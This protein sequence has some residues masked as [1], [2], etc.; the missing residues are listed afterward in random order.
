M[1][2]NNGRFRIITLRILV[3]IFGRP[4][5][6]RFALCYRTVVC[7]VLSVPLVYCGQT[8]GWTTMPLRTGIV[9]SPGHIVLDGTQLPSPKEAQQ[10]PQFS[11]NVYC[12]QTDAHLSN[13][14]ALFIYFLTSHD[15]VLRQH[16]VLRLWRSGRCL[17]TTSGRRLSE[18]ETG[19]S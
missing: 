12:G 14:W 8:V 10:P 16:Y 13:F 2:N 3:G 11:A 1:P 18:V 7:P 17:L 6:K 15:V 5:L 9:L 19:S 4:F